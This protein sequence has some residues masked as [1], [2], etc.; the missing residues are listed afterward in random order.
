MPIGDDWHPALEEKSYPV[1]D[2]ARILKTRELL[3]IADRLAPAKAA[4]AETQR[5]LALAEENLDKAK[6]ENKD[7]YFKVSDIGNEF[8]TALNKK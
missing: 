2:D 7:A 4:F 5:K 6:S 3:A 8:D 1:G